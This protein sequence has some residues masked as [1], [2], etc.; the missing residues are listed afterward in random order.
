MRWKAALGAAVVVGGVV[1]MEATPATADTDPNPSD[2]SSR[3]GDPYACE[4]P[5]L[6]EVSP[7]PDPL[8]Q[9]LCSIAVG[10]AQRIPVGTITIPFGDRDGHIVR[11]GQVV[12]RYGRCGPYGLALVVVVEPVGRPKRLPTLSAYA[13]MDRWVEGVAAWGANRL[14]WSGVDEL[15]VVWDRGRDAKGR[16]LVRLAG[17]WQYL[18]TDGGVRGDAVYEADAV[19][20]EQAWTA[21]THRF[22]HRRFRF[23]EGAGR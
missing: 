3:T 13:F 4:I 10:V 22:A 20:L 21:P 7:A 12:E 15:R 23:P 18:P 5:T 14:G 6:I 17:H 2:V 1:A 11:E 9:S 8:Q 19:L 16:Q